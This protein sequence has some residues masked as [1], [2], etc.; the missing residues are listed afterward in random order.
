MSP[1]TRQKH[2]SCQGNRTT[3]RRVEVGH[4]LLVLTSEN[5][6]DTL[7]PFLRQEDRMIPAD[8]Y[9][10]RLSNGG[11]RGLGVSCTADGLYLGRTR[12]VCRPAASRSQAAFPSRLRRCQPGPAY[13]WPHHRGLGLDA[14][15]PVACSDRGAPSSTS[16]SI[17]RE[18]PAWI[19]GGRP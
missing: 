12:L 8:H 13:T 7:A 17:G 5:K 18:C 11:A 10:W 14:R 6:T 2:R 1:A 16:G 3:P 15:E 4:P 19:G 9:V